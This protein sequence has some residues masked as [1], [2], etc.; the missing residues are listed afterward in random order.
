M[1]RYSKRKQITR[2][3]DFESVVLALISNSDSKG[4]RGLSCECHKGLIC[5]WTLKEITDKNF[6]IDY[7]WPT[8]V[9]FDWD[10]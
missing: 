9:F 3:D 8:D 4:T 1:I 7:N 2:V 10:Y 5:N 6:V